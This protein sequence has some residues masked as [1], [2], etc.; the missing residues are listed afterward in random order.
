MVLNPLMALAGSLLSLL[1]TLPPSALL[2][3]FAKR[4]QGRARVTLIASLGGWLAASSLLA[5]FG[6]GWSPYA[7]TILIA[8][9]LASLP[10]LISALI[11]VAL[12]H[13]MRKRERRSTPS[14]P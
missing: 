13:A 3:C 6:Y 1:I 7:S 4:L 8:F 5:L 2:F 9:G 11:Y 10:Y 12:C 14:S